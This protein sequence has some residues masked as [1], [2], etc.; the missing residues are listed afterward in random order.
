LNK[1]QIEIKVLRPIIKV[2]K[3]FKNVNLSLSNLIHKGM[4]YSYFIGIDISK[5]TLEFCLLKENIIL[6]NRSSQNSSKGIQSFMKEA[7]SLIGFNAETALF[8]M[9]HTGIYNNHLL[10]Y[11]IDKHCHIW[12][13]RGAQIKYSLG[14]QRGK[15]D[16]VDAERIAIYAYKNRESVKLWTPPRV[17]IQQLRSLT[18]LRSR[19]LKCL[20]QLSVPLKESRIFG[21][22]KNHIRL[23]VTLCRSS[24]S[25]IKRDLDKVNKQIQELIIQDPALNRLFNIVTSVDGIGVVT[26][27]EIIV[28]TNEFKSINE[29]KKYACYSGVAPFEHTSGSSLRGKN[30][31]SHMANKTIKQL[32]HLCALTSIQKPGELQEYYLRK[33]KEGKNKMLIINAIRNKLIL[34]IFSCIRN[35]RFY[36]KKLALNLVGS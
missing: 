13:E 22:E 24:I 20:S 2:L 25:S 30:R 7:K 27:V 17:I 35:D 10:K 34:R 26:A 8:C 16:K 3:V 9:E 29:A 15:N 4:N 28:T 31:V 19:L 1:L 14:V 33:V 5:D 18:S 11:L 21:L 23:E 32:L 6:L 36:Q 12:L